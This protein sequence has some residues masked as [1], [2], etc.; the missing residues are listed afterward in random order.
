MTAMAMTMIEVDTEAGRVRRYIHGLEPAAATF[1]NFVVQE[2]APSAVREFTTNGWDTVFAVR[3]SDVNGAITR[4]ATSPK[5]WEATLPA[6]FVAPELLASGTFGTWQLATG[7][8][9]GIV[10]MAIPFE[11]TITGTAAPVAVRGGVATVSVR[12]QYLPPEQGLPVCGSTPDSREGAH[13][14][15]LDRGTDS[16]RSVGALPV[17]VNSVTYAAPQQQDG[18]DGVLK[19]ML[20]RSL[21]GHL[22][23]FQHVFATVDIAGSAATDAFRWLKPTDRSY[24]YAEP[25]IGATLDN[26]VFAVLTM[27]ECRSRGSAL[28][29]I[30]PDAIP[31]GSRAGFTIAELLLMEKMILPNLAHE[32]PGTDASYFRLN[33]NSTQITNTK[34]FAL[35]PARV[36]AVD[37]TPVMQTLR[38]TVSGDVIETYSYLRTNISPG[39]DAWAEI[40]HYATLELKQNADGT[41]SIGYREAQPPV[42]RT[43]HDVAVW[44]E[45]VSVA[46]D[47]IV[48]IAT[49]GAAMAVKKIANVIVRVI[50]S[51][52][53]GAVVAAIPAIL[54]K[55]PQ[56]IAGSL[57]LPPIDA[58][59]A[60][61]TSAVKWTD[62]RDFKITN[63]SLNGALQL[64][65][66]PQ[67]A[68]A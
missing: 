50:V 64:G 34:P 62:A 49:F 6:S 35:P 20:A 10:N 16:R 68:A 44:V 48:G 58:F 14:L 1:V 53:I 27:T 61:A 5:T 66:D 37:Y 51:I 7:G 23:E 32:Y 24:A 11:C 8:S 45:V 21:N 63:L 25:T 19:E 13:R 33:S 60:N 46:V 41:Q 55:I 4:R 57:P 28:Q 2:P 52:L 38:V 65:G 22:D 9:G 36:G 54:S 59:V 15:V 18:L 30:S 67:F 17:T 43:G 56:F 29:Q 12:L 39:I 3:A 26:A 47:A 42:E 31:P 40:T